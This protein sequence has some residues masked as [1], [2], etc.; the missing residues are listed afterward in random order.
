[1]AE[2]QFEVWHLIKVL[3]VEASR[4]IFRQVQIRKQKPQV[5]GEQVFFLLKS[6]HFHDLM[7]GLETRQSVFF[8][9][10]F[11]LNLLNLFDA[12]FLNLIE[13]AFLENLV[14]VLVL[15]SQVVQLAPVL[16]EVGRVLGV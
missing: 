2:I 10:D 1:M 15:D 3:L 7:E 13:Y 8:N 11:L 14:G 6:M 9:D 5:A 4:D 16:R 12:Q